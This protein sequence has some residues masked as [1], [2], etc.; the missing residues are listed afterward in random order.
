MIGDVVLTPDEL[1]GLM[2]EFLTSLQPPNGTT[3]FAAWLAAN[4]DEVGTAYTSELARH[5]RRPGP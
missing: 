2:D 3:S 1:R 4:R 5:F